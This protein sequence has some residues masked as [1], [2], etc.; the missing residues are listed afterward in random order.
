[1]NKMAESDEYLDYRD[2]TLERFVR[3]VFR[4]EVAGFECS[5]PSTLD[6]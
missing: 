6:R 3:G 5:K 4:D 1:M 2:E